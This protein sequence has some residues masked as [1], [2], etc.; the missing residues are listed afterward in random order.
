VPLLGE[1]QV[2]HLTAGRLD[3][4]FRKDVPPTRYSD[5]RKVLHGFLSWLVVQ[6]ALR[7][8]PLANVQSYQRRDAQRRSKDREV[9]TEDLTAVLNAIEAW[10]TADRPGPRPSQVYR[11][12]VLFIAGTACRPGEALAVRRDDIDFDYPV[13]PGD[14]RPVVHLTGTVVV[15]DETGKL[16][17]QPHTK[18]RGAGDRTVILP[19][20]VA[21]MLRERLAAT[22]PNG[23]G[24][25]FATRSGNLAVAEQRQHPAA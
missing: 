2:R 12:L 13:A 11:D 23:T 6:G 3:A 19:A 9:T 7:T 25:V 16:T 15:D 14:T 22:P 5:V 1:L 18:G 4:Y 21:A 20:F 8:D 10:M 17:R 24:A